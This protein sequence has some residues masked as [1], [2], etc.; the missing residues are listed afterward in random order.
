[1]VVLS[2]SAGHIG[3]G[4]VIVSWAYR[5]WWWCCQLGIARVC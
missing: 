2:L 4:V 1:V 3:G 5:W